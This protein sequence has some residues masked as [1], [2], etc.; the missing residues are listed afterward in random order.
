MKFDELL[1]DD[2]LLDALYDMH[3]DECT[4]IQERAIPP[5]LEG[6]DLI[7]VAQTG[8]GKTA[9]YLLPVIERLV[10]DGYPTDTVNCVVMAPTRELAQQIDQQM[11]GFS[12]FLPVT[13]VA[14]YGGT[15]GS[16]YELQRKSLKQ[17]VD[18]VVATPGRLLAHLSMGYVD[19]SNVGFFILDEADRMLDMGFLDDIMQII[20]RLPKERQTLMFSATMPPKIQ[21]LAQNILKN[22]AEVKI[23]VSKPAEKIH[24]S[25]YVCYDTQKMPI[26]IDVFDKNEYNKVII[27]SGSKL[28]VKELTRA[29]RQ[30]KIKAAEMHSD[31]DQNQREEV[32]LKFKAGKINVLVAT[33]IMARGIDIDDIEMVVNYDVPREAEDYVHR[34]GRT[35]RADRDGRAI[36]FVNEKDMGKFRGIERLLEK[37]VEKLPVDPSFGST[38]VYNS[39]GPAKGRNRR[40]RGRKQ[41][42]GGE[43]PKNK[44][45]NRNDRGGRRRNGGKKGNS[46]S[47]EPNAIAAPQDVSQNKHT[48]RNTNKPS[49]RRRH[50]HSGRKPDAPADNATS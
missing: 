39:E 17:G 33:D 50:R 1:H 28:K 5:V 11:Q 14:I 21:Q 47:R 18:V 37:E 3:F 35:A 20:G 49:S 31:L 10:A 48:G 6:R 34:I 36:T 2:D 44:G 26:L 32:I 19:L 25:A 12:Y 42:G 27:F 15:D 43:S 7:A 8:T 23:A 41:D 38:P 9:A 4:P 30:K 13:S 29:L 24:Q 40:R 16:T 22:P 46:D 45:D